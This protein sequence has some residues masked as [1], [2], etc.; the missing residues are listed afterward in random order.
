MHS[1]IEWNCVFSF[2][3]FIFVFQDVHVFA[4]E[5]EEYSSTPNTGKRRYVVTSYAQLWHNIQYLYKHNQPAT[6]YEIIPEGA[7]CK[8]Y[9]DLEFQKEFN[10]E[11]D[12]VTMVTDLIK[13]IALLKCGCYLRDN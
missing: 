11:L 8:L 5:P 7:A 10:P 1:K 3:E 13:V 4:Y 12:G 6:F 2:S 9:F